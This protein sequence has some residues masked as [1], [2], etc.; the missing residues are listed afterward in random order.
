MTP[1]DEE[2]STSKQ[3]AILGLP[4][5]GASWPTS[6]HWF[7]ASIATLRLSLLIPGSPMADM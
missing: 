1:G 3:S 7:H 6:L 4:M 5:A 2:L